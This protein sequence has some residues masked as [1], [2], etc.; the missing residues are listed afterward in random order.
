MPLIEN[1]WRRFRELNPEYAEV[2]QPRSFYFCDNKKD[3]DE[4]AELVAN[5]I[6][7]ATSP[8]AWWFEKH[9]EKLPRV[10][11]LAII[12]NW[13]EEPRAIVRTTGVELVEFRHITPEYA[14]IEGEGDRS[15]EYWKKVHWEYYA[16]EMK[17][18]GEYPTEHMEIVCEYFETIW[19][20]TKPS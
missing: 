8:S 17:A 11:D 13:D 1:Y 14:Y 15:L 16:N 5:K 7:Q 18:F 19:Q 10:G 3:A 12:T 9:H 4:C 2:D 20:G 6:K